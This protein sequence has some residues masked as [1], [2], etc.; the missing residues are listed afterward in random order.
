MTLAVWQPPSL[1]QCYEQLHTMNWLV[2]GALVLGAALGVVITLR[3]LRRD[4]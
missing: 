4:R 3:A 1:W 2:L